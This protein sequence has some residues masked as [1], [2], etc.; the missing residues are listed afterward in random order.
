MEKKEYKKPNAK[1]ILLDSIGT[2][3]TGSLEGVGEEIDGDASVQG[4]RRG[5]SWDEE[6]EE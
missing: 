5:F 6:D 4:H 1:T 2:L 3:L